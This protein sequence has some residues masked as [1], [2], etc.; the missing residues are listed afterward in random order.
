MVAAELGWEG[1]VTV[2]KVDMEI[3][4]WHEDYSR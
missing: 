4:M 3:Q 2:H 1:L